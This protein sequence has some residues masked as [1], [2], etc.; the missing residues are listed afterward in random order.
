M[1]RYSTLVLLLALVGMC[2]AAA[3]PAP[4]PAA[5]N[6]DLETAASA[7]AQFGYGGYGG[8]GGYGHGGH[9]HGGYGH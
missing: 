3:V 5:A 6:D 1:L 2:L 7:R 4:I 8:H 9:R